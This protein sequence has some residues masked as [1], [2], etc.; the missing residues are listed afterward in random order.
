MNAAAHYN[1]LE[2]IEIQ[3]Q[4]DDKR[5]YRPYDDLKNIQKEVDWTFNIMDWED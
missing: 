1:M 5:G 4:K 2:A 3:K